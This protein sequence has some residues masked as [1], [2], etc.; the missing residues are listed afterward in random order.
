MIVVYSQIGQLSFVATRA[1]AQGAASRR[2]V[3]PGQR[4]MCKGEHRH[5]WYLEAHR[6]GKSLIL[7]QMADFPTSE[8]VRD[9]D[10]S[11]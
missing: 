1:Q 3:L 5:W 6:T 7:L 11:I 9:F 8:G 4:A 2:D 10:K